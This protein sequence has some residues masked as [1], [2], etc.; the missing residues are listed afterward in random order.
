M[1]LAFDNIKV[2]LALVGGFSGMVPARHYSYERK[3]EG[4]F[5]KV[6]VNHVGGEYSGG[7]IAM[8]GSREM[9]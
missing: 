6:G 2:L 4:G 3:N 8:K 5:E 7:I 1:T 9:E